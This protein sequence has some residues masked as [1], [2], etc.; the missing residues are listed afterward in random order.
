MSAAAASVVGFDPLRDKTYQSTRLGRDVA[1]FLA[2]MSLGGAS[3]RTLDQ[4][5]RDLARGA[6]MFPDH[7]ITDL[8]DGDMLHIARAFKDRERKSRVAAWRSFYRWGKRSRRT[9]FD[10]TEA[11]PTFKAQPKKVYDIFSETEIE[12]LCGLPRPDGT[13]MAILIDEGFR[14]GEARNFQVRHF[15]PDP[16]DATPWGNVVVEHGKGGKGRVIRASKRVGTGIAEMQVLDGMRDRD[17]LWYGWRANAVSRRMLR[18][19]ACGEGTFARWWE[20]SL[21]EAGVRRRN[22]HMTRHTFAT[23]WLRRGGRL[24]RLSTAMGHASI[25]TTYDLY[26]H[27]DQGDVAAELAL[28]EGEA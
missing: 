3:P 12:M 6:L 21:E 1:D 25:K 5:E 22:P 20:R 28:I 23:R 14:K 11:L 24:E 15:R 9:T 2:W 17:Y 26:G 4:Y 18:D 19:R 7:G 27:L 13:L 10:P 16:S 8:S